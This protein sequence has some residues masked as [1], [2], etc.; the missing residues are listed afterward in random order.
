MPKTE[1][2]VLEVAPS[3]ETLARAVWGS[4]AAAGALSACGGGAEAGAR[5]LATTP[6]PIYRPDLLPRSAGGPS[7]GGARASAPP[8]TAVQLFDWAQGQYPSLFDSLQPDQTVDGIVFRHYPGTGHY[9]GVSPQGRV[10]LLGPYSG[11]QVV[12][13]GA[14]QS[15]AAAVQSALS[16]PSTDAEAARFLMHA[17]FSASEAE[18]AAVRQQGYAGWLDAQLALP[19]GQTGWDWLVSRGY[20]AIDT[21]EYFFANGMYR[22]MVWQQL[23]QAQDAVRKRWAVA[24]SEVFVVAWRGIK[25]VM[26]WDTFGMAEY[27]DLLNRHAFGTYRDLLEALTLNPAMGAFLST[28]GNA[29]EDPTTG[30]LPDEN[31]ARE[32]MQLFSIGLYELNLDGT[33][34]L[35]AQG[36]PIETYTSA[37]VSN[38]ARVFTGYNHNYGLGSFNSPKPP[39]FKVF[40]IETA[41]GR[42]PLDA[43]LHSGLEKRFLGT[44]IP[45]N[46][47]GPESLRRALDVLANHPNNGPFLCRQFIQR[48]VTS[49]PSPAYVQRVASVFNNNGAGVRGDLKAVLRAI[50]LDEEARGASGLLSPTFGRLREPMLRIAQWGRTFQAVSKAGTWKLDFSAFSAR[51]DIYQYPLDPPSVFSF[52]RP[53]YVPP[54]TAMAVTGAT[55][56]EFQIVNESTV[57]AWINLLQDFCAQG[58]WVRAPE[59]IYRPDGIAPTPTDGPDIVPDYTVE[60]SLVTHTQALVDRLNLLLCANQLSAATVSLIVRSLQ[61]DQI[62]DDSS[63]EFKKVHVGRAILFVMSAADYLVQR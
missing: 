39:Y 1:M 23:F 59:F 14:L 38:L 51:T 21:H 56:P 32:V 13:V 6:Q 22:F 45:A 61:A 46:T 12:D 17:Q 63:D 5:A 8:I 3:S 54:G 35:D 50:V 43:N 9:L 20:S 4:V 2:D 37:D 33:L 60:K 11:G 41:R 28:R 58:I 48:L 7:A 42:M 29:K 34:K 36:R 57:A 49:H 31:Y 47:S 62:R 24:L 25:D 53:G 55:A 27:W 15:F 40:N 19:V 18:I 10:L 16:R 26:N 44:V 30:R 52:F